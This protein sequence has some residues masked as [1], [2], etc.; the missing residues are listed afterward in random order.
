MTPQPS[1][2][3]AFAAALESF[4]HEALTRL[5]ESALEQRDRAEA[6]IRCLL[7][8]IPAKGDWQ[9]IPTTHDPI[10]PTSNRQATKRQATASKHTP[11]TAIDFSISLEDL[12]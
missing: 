7:V 2:H 4:D 10:S 3:P 8:T 11:S 6:Q 9:P 1:T 5:Y 12:I